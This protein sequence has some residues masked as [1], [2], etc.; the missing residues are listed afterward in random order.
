MLSS[1]G[2]RF[3]PTLEHV[4]GFGGDLLSTIVHGSENCPNRDSRD[5]VACAWLALRAGVPLPQ[6][7]PRFAGEESM[8]VFLRSGQLAILSKSWSMARTEA[9]RALPEQI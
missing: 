8:A 3:A 2:C 4:N 6:L 7:A 1:I 9:L 5:H